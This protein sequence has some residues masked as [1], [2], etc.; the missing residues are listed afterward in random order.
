MY[1]IGRTDIKADSGQQRCFGVFDDAAA[2]WRFVEQ[3]R[4]QMVGTFTVFE[5]VEVPE[6]PAAPPPALDAI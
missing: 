1:F 2:A 6:P 4:G 3:L 5:G